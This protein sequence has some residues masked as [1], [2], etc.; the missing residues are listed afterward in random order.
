MQTRKTDGRKFQ[1]LGY[2]QGKKENPGRAVADGWRSRPQ[3]RRH[4]PM[5]VLNMALFN[6]ADGWNQTFNPI[7]ARENG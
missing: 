6:F 2:R 1:L 3:R 4:D 7:K 5:L